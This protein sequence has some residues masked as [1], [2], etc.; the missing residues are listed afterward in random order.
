MEL[1]MLVKV[2]VEKTDT[3]TEFVLAWAKARQS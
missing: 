1:K 3:E 2:L